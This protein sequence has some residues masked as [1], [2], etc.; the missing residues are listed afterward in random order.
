[1]VTWQQKQ[2]VFVEGQ[3]DGSIEKEIPM[4]VARLYRFFGGCKRL[5]DDVHLQKISNHT[6]KFKDL[7]K[8]TCY[9]SLSQGV[10]GTHFRSS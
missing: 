3:E 1:M 4:E 10:N 7:L 5:Q 9:F 6:S 2:N 8:D